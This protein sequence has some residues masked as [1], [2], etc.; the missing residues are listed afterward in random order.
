M[1]TSL[2]SCH[3]YNER[4]FFVCVCMCVNSYVLLYKISLQFVKVLAKRSFSKSVY[5]GDS[6]CQKCQRTSYFC[7]TSGRLAYLYFACRSIF[8]GADPH[9]TYLILQKPHYFSQKF[10][11][12]FT[13]CNLVLSL[14]IYP[15]L[16]R[17][18]PAAVQ[19][20]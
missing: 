19:S 17:S 5:F 1:N 14:W 12:W 16:Q 6:L 4:V 7:L 13:I 8:S 2:Q 9:W 20:S 15:V 3:S 10:S 11:C 18:N